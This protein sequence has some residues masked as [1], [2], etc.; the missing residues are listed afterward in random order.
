MK[1]RRPQYPDISDI[2]AHKAAGRQQRA[3]LSFAEKLAILDALR[4]R[5][6]PIIQAREFRRR[7]RI[8]PHGKSD[9][10]DGLRGGGLYPENA[11]GAMK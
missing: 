5:V 4:E 1:T 10:T 11:S 6:K 8:Q 7:Q 9:S 3:A 2:L